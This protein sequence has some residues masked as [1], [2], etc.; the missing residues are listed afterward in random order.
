MTWSLTLENKKNLRSRFLS[1]PFSGPAVDL[2]T[3]ELD[4]SPTSSPSPRNTTGLP[5]PGLTTHESSRPSVTRVTTRHDR[6]R[7][8]TRDQGQDRPLT[9]RKTGRTHYSRSRSLDV[10]QKVGRATLTTRNGR[11]I[12]EGTGSHR[13]D[14]NRRRSSVPTSVSV[15]PTHPTTSPNRDG[16]GATAQLVE[17]ERVSAL[18]AKTY[19]SPPGKSLA[20][21]SVRTVPRCHEDDPS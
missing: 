8:T 10:R 20:D 2:F 21:D 17:S 6:G 7:G 11:G 14:K 5:R 15:T 4:R 9:P 16:R 12:G 19:P 1:C 3:E 18:V 13:L